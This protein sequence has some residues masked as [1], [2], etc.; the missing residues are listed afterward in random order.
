[1]IIASNSGTDWRSVRIESYPREKF[2]S[3][4]DRDAC[5]AFSRWVSGAGTETGQ[6][7]DVQVGGSNF[8]VSTFELREGQLTKLAT[9]RNGQML[10]FAFSANSTD[11]LNAIVDS[12]K[13]FQP[14]K[15]K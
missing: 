11:V 10:S 9:V 15:G 1:M 2:G 7:T 8:V 3:V 5:R 14:D 4:N 13:T 6:P 12:M